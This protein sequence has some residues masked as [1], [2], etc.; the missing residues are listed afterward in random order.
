MIS[1]SIK[2]ISS[3]LIVGLLSACSSKQD[4]ISYQD[5]GENVADK[6]DNTV[7]TE[8]DNKLSNIQTIQTKVLDE[9]VSKIGQKS[10]YNTVT[11]T[12]DGKTITLTSIHFGFGL[13]KMND[14]MIEISKENSNEIAPIVNSNKNVKIKLEG[15]CDE[16]GND[17][18]NFALGLRRAKTVKDSLINN[19]INGSN[20]IV[21]SLGEGN[22]ICTDQT[23]SCWKK[24]RRVDHR[25]IK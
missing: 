1:K 7:D 10:Y 3:I 2:L 25:F 11:S 23:E 17:E 14:E 15:N 19:G 5:N 13:Y 18:F 22:P 12:I 4:T 20:I 9:G 6:I 8:I 21:V 24:N 16:W